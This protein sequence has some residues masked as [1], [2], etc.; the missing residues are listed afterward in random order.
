MQI[1]VSN[2]EIVDKYT[3]L[4][5]K[6]DEI[7]DEE[8]LKNIRNE[9]SLLFTII[10]SIPVKITDFM[11]LSRVNR[12]LWDVEDDLRE[13]EKQQVFDDYFIQLAR[14]VY[15]LNDERAAI[16]KQINLSTG[17]NLVEEKSY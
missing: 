15:K 5:I 14:S 10:A 9:I 1:E 17:S 7:T 16:K 8:K 6:A 11:D 4:L 3:I 2:G 12:E 13:C